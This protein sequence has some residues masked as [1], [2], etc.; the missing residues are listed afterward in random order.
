MLA[1]LILTTCEKHASHGQALTEPSS[2]AEASSD[3]SQLMRN[4]VMEE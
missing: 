3:S 2:E 1:W 4:R